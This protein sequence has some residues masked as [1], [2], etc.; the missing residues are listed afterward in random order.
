MQ[1]MDEC[2]RMISWESNPEVWGT[3]QPLEPLVPNRYAMGPGQ[4]PEW[5][6]GSSP[7]YFPPEQPSEN[8]YN[9]KLQGTANSL[10][11]SKY[12]LTEIGN[13][14]KDSTE[15]TKCGHGFASC[16]RSHCHFQNSTSN[17]AEHFACSPPEDGLSD[18]CH[19]YCKYSTTRYQGQT[20]PGQLQVDERVS[21][22]SNIQHNFVSQKSSEYF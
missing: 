20:E 10:N 4:Q 7:D 2:C 11:L 3:N 19:N 22:T 15:A 1:P 9:K 5:T 12:D 8:N 14:E 21:T 18:P 13:F 17:S 6:F 16:N